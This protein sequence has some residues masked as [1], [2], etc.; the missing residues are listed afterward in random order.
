MRKIII[1]G[2]R[3][4]N[5]YENFKKECDKLITEKVEIVWGG[6]SGVDAMAKRYADEKGHNNKLFKADWTAFGK[7]AGPI[8]NQKMAEYGDELIAFWDGKSRGTRNMIL[9]AKEK[10]E[11]IAVI[12]IDE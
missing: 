6:A 10:L 8:R 12:I 11:K 9:Q 3:N 7:S 4:Y 2:C 5:D 1:A